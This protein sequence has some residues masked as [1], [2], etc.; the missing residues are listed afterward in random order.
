MDLVV[1]LRGR[2]WIC[3]RGAKM[4]KSGIWRVLS[5]GIRALIFEVSINA[6]FAVFAEVCKWFAWLENWLWF[7][8]GLAL[9]LRR[10]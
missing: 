6:G 1:F 9:D 7:G 8:F 3:A 5:F 10:L 4:Q 2:V